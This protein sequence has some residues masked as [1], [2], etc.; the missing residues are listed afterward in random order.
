MKMGWDEEMIEAISGQFPLGILG[1][2][3][4]FKFFFYLGFE[5]MVGVC[6]LEVCWQAYP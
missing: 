4:F 5:L 3:P 1:K 2:I 6:L